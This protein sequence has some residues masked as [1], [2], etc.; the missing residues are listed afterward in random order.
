MPQLSLTVGAPRVTF[1]ATF[2]PGWWSRTRPGQMMVGGW[3]SLTVTVKV[4]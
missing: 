3:L 2:V 1:V 4:H